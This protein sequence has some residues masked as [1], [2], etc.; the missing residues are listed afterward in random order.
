MQNTVKTSLFPNFLFFG[1]IIITLFTSSFYQQVIMLFS[2][3][4]LILF[5]IYY[6]KEIKVTPIF[7]SFLLFILLLIINSIFVS[8][9]Y[10]PNTTKIIVIMLFSYLLGYSISTELCRTF[11]KILVGI[12]CLLAIWAIFQ[13]VTR[14][15]YHVDMVFRSNTIF[16]TPNS[17]AAGINFLLIPL[18][19]F[20]FSEF[21]TQ[22]IKARIV[23]VVLFVSLLVTIS[24]GGW[25]SFSCALI[26]YISLLFFFSIISKPKSILK[27]LL[28]LLSIC[29]CFGFYHQYLKTPVYNTFFKPTTK[30]EN[31][32]NE[33]SITK[34]LTRKITPI[35]S[36][37]QARFILYGIAWA[38]LKNNLLLGIGTDNFTYILRKNKSDIT[39]GFE[40][41]RF[42]HNDYLQI[43]L[44]TGV[45]GLFILLAL[46][47]TIYFQSWVCLKKHNSNKV[48]II[49]LLSGITT[50]FCHA[51]VDFV[52][53]VPIL[54]LFFG[55][56]LGV[57]DK[58]CA[59]H[60][61]VKTINLNQTL[62]I[63]KS[64][65]Y[66]C[67]ILVPIFMVLILPLC[68][69]M[70]V[71]SARVYEHHNH[72]VK[73]Q[74]YYTLARRLAPYE[75]KYT[76]GEAKLW[77]KAVKNQKSADAAAMVDELLIKGINLNSY[78][79]ESLLLRSILHR[80]H[81]KLLTNPAD[82]NEIIKWQ[83]E[84]IEWQPYNLKAHKQYIKTL[85]ETNNYEKLKKHNAILKER[86][87]L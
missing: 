32:D 16:H 75:E 78:E 37:I 26:F 21:K 69:H 85:R 18:L 3:I 80:D 17:Y 54:V 25:L 70:V 73:A 35:N 13:Y 5:S 8:P 45:I 55:L 57:L 77:L 83:E 44:E 34:N 27:Q 86:F 59:K 31:V 15:S 62:N 4:S 20:Y 22:S 79:K 84:V 6:L 23:I 49:A 10:N 19:A 1:I 52:F 51:M 24:R 38:E 87:E 11:F 58:E 65:I 7:C 46:I 33:V 53:Y 64:F 60:L 41:T 30:I 50:Y 28:I 2:C 36:S 47:F 82:L 40:D 42:V 63:K 14:L 29:A 61:D 68:A 67:M 66:K 71:Y 81:N 48:L 9:N 76:Y 56:A 74:N 43:L 72:F 12:F 39:Y